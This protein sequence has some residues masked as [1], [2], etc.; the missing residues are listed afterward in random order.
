MIF[1]LIFR[2]I[3]IVC[4]LAMTA[5]SFSLLVQPNPSL[6]KLSVF[7]PGQVVVELSLVLVSEILS[8]LVLLS[9][10]INM[11]LLTPAKTIQLKSQLNTYRFLI[12]GGKG[13]MYLLMTPLTQRL[14]GSFL[15]GHKDDEI[16]RV[17]AVIKLTCIFLSTG[18]GSYSR[19][20][21]EE[22]S[23]IIID[24]KKTS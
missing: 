7:L 11:H 15:A 19:F 4:A 22:S 13:L 12:Y 21:R 23:K 16:A 3:H 18:V 9:G 1:K 24:P 10:L 14:V 6:K 5:L 20:F 2:I 8:T 17:T